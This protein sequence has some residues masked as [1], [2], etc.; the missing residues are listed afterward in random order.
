MYTNSTIVYSDTAVAST[1]GEIS[2][3]HHTS[4]IYFHNTHASTA[5]SVKLNGNRSV[6]IPAGGTTYVCVPGDYTKFEVT[7]TSVTLAMYAVG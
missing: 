3:S 1:D 6:L 2:L 7:T 4:A 5:A